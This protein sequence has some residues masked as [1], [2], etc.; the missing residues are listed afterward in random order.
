MRN[1]I[2]RA[3]LALIVGLL[4]LGATVSSVAD[5]PQPMR[6]EKCDSLRMTSHGAVPNCP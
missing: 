6:V 3:A 2:F 1:F 4:L 5:A